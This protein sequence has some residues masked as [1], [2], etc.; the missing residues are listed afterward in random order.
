MGCSM[1][2]VARKQEATTVKRKGMVEW[3]DA[4][5]FQK[6]ELVGSSGR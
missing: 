6:G 1:E 2:G 4:M 3:V 5:N